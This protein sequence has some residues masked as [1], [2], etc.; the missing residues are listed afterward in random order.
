MHPRLPGVDG[1]EVALEGAV[2]ELGDLAG[3]LDAGRPGAD[4]DEG[5]QVVDVVAARGAELGQLEGAEDPAAQLEGVVDALHARARTRRT[6]RGRSRTGPAP[7]AT[8]SESYG[9]TVSRP[10]TR[11]VTVRALEVDV[12]D[13][14]EQDPG[15]VLAAEDLAGRRGDLALG[16]DAGGDL[17]EQ[18]LEQVVGGLGDHRHVDVGRAAAP[19]VPKSPPKPEP[20]T[21][22]RC[23]AAVEGA[24]SGHAPGSTRRAG[25]SD[26][27]LGWGIFPAEARGGMTCRH[28]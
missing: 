11:E 13:L 21:T 15:V 3:H 1:A 14:A 2:G 12:G 20:I 23:R 26:H 22:T 10:R 27:R 28:A 5:Q 4:D 25:H 6:R 9:V 18:R 7:A 19:C 16:E 8:I 24:F 17:V